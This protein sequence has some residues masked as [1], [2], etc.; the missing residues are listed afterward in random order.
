VEGDP[1]QQP[2]QIQEGQANA[3]VNVPSAGQNA[4]NIFFQTI[5]SFFTSLIPEP[6]PPLEIN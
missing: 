2:Q 4:W 5:H 6:A 1:N 3:P